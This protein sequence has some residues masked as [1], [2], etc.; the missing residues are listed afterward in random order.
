LHVFRAIFPP[1]IYLAA[2][3]PVGLRR[4]REECTGTCEGIRYRACHSCAC[5]S[6][7][8][9]YKRRVQLNAPIILFVDGSL[10]TAG[11]GERAKLDRPFDVDRIM[12]ST[13]TRHLQFQV[14]RFV[15]I[16]VEP[17]VPMLPLITMQTNRYPEQ[18]LAAR[19]EAWCGPRI[20]ATYTSN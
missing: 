10:T 1:F 8:R 5:L 13:V 6:G 18:P 15:N 12:L 4:S 7:S 9:S 20:P 11:A 17:H 3:W 2:L 16:E 14:F 19:I